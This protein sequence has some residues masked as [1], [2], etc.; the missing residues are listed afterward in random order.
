MPLVTIGLPVYN[1]ERYL[2]QALEA[3]L[4]QDYHNI[5]L[6]ISDNASSD[7]TEMICQQS[8]QRDSRVIY[9]RRPH[10]GGAVSNFNRVLSMARGEYFMWA[11]ADDLWEPSYVSSLVAALSSNEQAV[12][13]FAALDNIDE[14]GTTVRDYP[15]LA[16]L[17]HNRRLLRLLKYIFQD[18]RAGKANLIYGLMRRKAIQE[19]G[20]LTIWGNGDWG[21]DMLV[22]FRLLTGGQSVFVR[23]KLFHKRRSELPEV[24]SSRRSYRSRLSTLLVVVLTHLR[25]RRGYY[26]GYQRIIR[27]SPHLSNADR[28]FLLAALPARE[29]QV[30]ANIMWNTIIHRGLIW[31]VEEARPMNRLGRRQ[32]IAPDAHDHTG[33]G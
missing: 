19:A 4:A 6:I 24:S 21:A 14:T 11:A 31:V 13:A 30:F 17:P 5:E 12:L 15:A 16:D 28:L 1:G 22:V 9:M 7:T 2:P 10:N 32:S 25:D 18:E 8:V 20:G 23:E 33:V 26:R 3:L 29:A 27:S